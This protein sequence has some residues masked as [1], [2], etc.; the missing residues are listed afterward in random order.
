MSGKARWF[1]DSRG[2]GLIGQV[3]GSDLFVHYS[4]IAGEGCRTLKG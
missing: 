4:D 1:S 3:G 2:Y